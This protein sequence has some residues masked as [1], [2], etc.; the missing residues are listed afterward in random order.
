MLVLPPATVK[1]IFFF[2]ADPPSIQVHSSLVHSDHHKLIKDQ[3]EEKKKEHES[4]P[5]NK[6]ETKGSTALAHLSNDIM[7]PPAGAAVTVTRARVSAPTAMATAA[8]SRLLDDDLTAPAVQEQREQRR[9]EEEDRLHDAHGECG[10]QHRAGLIDVQGVVVDVLAI[11]AERP[12]GYPHRAAVPVGA[13]GI[14][15]EAQLVDAG[16]EGAEEEEVHK[17][18]EDGRA[19]GGG[20]ADERVDGPEDGDD[21]DDEEHEHVG[22]RQHVG[23]QVAIDEVGLRVG[24]RV[25]MIRSW[26]RKRCW[27][28][29]CGDEADQNSP[30]CQ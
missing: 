30:E 10:L 12:E 25:S 21:A 8:D 22:G 15:D 26:S 24:R 11:L 3:Y 23:F 20:E 2:S 16:N 28:W 1:F 4:N 9:P 27:R 19:L 29:R 13:V 17:G 6:T 7:R 5:P 18:D 14:G